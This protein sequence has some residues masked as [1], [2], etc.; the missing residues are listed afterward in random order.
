[1]AAP[2][3]VDIIEQVQRGFEMSLSSTKNSDGELNFFE[4]PDKLAFHFFKEF[5]RFEYALKAAGF[6]HGEGEARPNWD[7]F[8]VTVRPAFENVQLQ[9][10]KVAV[11]YMLSNPPKKQ[12][13]KNGKLDLD[14]GLCNNS[15]EA[16]K[17]LIYVRRVRNN[18]FHGGKFNGHWF[19]PQRSEE[20]MRHSLVILEACLAES[21]KVREA[22][23]HR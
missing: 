1:M 5:A 16:D 6:H 18:L 12:I 7:T 20:L 17:L 19:A 9:T 23:N 2:S 21:D 13:V 11:E 14:E 22:Y 4:Y 8:A 3:A 15:N 10:L